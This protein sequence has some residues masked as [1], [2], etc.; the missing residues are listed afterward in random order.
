MPKQLYTNLSGLAHRKRC[1]RGTIANHT[2]TGKLQP[3]AYLDRGH[4]LEPLFLTGQVDEPHREAELV[5]VD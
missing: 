1:D 5:K 2:R 3:D 4:K